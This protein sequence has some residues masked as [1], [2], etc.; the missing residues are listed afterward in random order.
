MLLAACALLSAGQGVA[1]VYKTV[2]ENGNVVYTDSPPTPDAKPLEMRPLSVIETVK[3]TP[4]AI[5]ATEADANK[6]GE[7]TSIRVLRRG[8][9]DF[10]LVSPVQEQTFSGN[11]NTATIAWDTRYRIEEGM[12]VTIFIDGKAQPP[13]TESVIEVSLLNRGEHTVTAELRDSRNRRVASA[14]PVTFY[15]RQNSVNFNR[16]NPTP[17]GGG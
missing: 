8:Y 16:P 15:I 13:T 11:R 17:G 1:E 12:S 7:V 9:R 5:P 10:R 2:D 3:I 4:R 6:D 14:D